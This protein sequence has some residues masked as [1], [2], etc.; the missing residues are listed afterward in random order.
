MGDTAIRLAGVRKSFDS[1]A[2]LQGVDLEVALGE[3]ITIIGG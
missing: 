1:L 3:T 2:V